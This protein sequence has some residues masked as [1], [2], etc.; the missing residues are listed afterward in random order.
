MK[1]N[2][3]PF[4][5]GMLTLLFI[6][7]CGDTQNKPS[8][9]DYP[10]NTNNPQT[11]DIN[12]GPQMIALVQIDGEEYKSKRGSYKWEK[13]QGEEN[14]T[15]IADALSPLEIA[16]TFN[17]ISTTAEANIAIEIKRD[18]E[19][20]VL[21]WEEKFDSKAIPLKNNQFTAPKKPGKYVYEIVSIWSNPD[22]LADGGNGRVSYTFVI[23][24]K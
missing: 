15:I 8:N 7:G 19:I 3:S 18:P 23:E 2:K 21:L 14:K 24:V 22:D 1:L 13:S 4:L 5:V 20:S 10:E 9:E 11:K 16:E 17:A 12:N 6:A